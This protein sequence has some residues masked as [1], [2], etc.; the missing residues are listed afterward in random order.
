MLL[1]GRCVRGADQG[2]GECVIERASLHFQTLISADLLSGFLR[3]RAKRYRIRRFYR[4][5][6]LPLNSLRRA[7]AAAHTTTRSQRRPMHR[8]AI[9]VLEEV[10]LRW[11]LENR[12]GCSVEWEAPHAGPSPGEHVQPRRSPSPI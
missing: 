9:L 6:H 11:Q 1:R 5:S 4:V 3:P 7:T 12:C 8:E 2:K 10:A